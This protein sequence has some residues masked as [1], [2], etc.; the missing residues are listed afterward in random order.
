DVAPRFEN[1]LFLSATPHNGHSNSF[2]ALLELL[3][4]QRFT[5]GVPVRP[6]ERDRVMV[7]RLKADLRQLGGKYP[8]RKVVRIELRHDGHGGARLRRDGDRWKAQ[9]NDEDERAVGQGPAAELRL[10]LLLRQYAELM[11]PKSGS[12]QLVFSNLQNRLLSSIEA[13]RRTLGVHARSLGKGRGR[14]EL[15][16]PVTAD[17]DEYGQDDETLE[18]ASSA[19]AEASSRLVKTPEGRARQLLDEMM[20]LV[21]QHRLAPDAKVLALV[22]WIRRHQCPAVRIGGG[23]EA[24]A[25]WSDTRVILFTEWGDTKRYLWQLLSTAVDGTDRGDER[26]MQ[27]HGGMSDDQREEVQTAFNAPPAEHPVRILIATD[28]AREGIN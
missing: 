6:E 2:S 11:K 15:R 7:R 25:R 19:A 9:A 21:E 17:D 27:F 28:A 22:D 10:S 13:F 1:R 8:E 18:V 5:R 14:F 4:P 16:I 23:C 20:R 12:G 3:D 26:I 24:G